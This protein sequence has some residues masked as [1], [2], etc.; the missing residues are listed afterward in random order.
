MKKTRLFVFA[1]LIEAA[2]ASC[3]KEENFEPQQQPE[4]PEVATVPFELSAC[5]ENSQMPTRLSL[6]KDFKPAWEEGDQLG[7]YDGVKIQ[8]FDLTNLE[9]STFTGSLAEGATQLNAIYPYGSATAFSGGKFT[10]SIP[11]EQVIEQGDSLATDA[12]LAMAQPV[13]IGEGQVQF[14]F[15]N[16]CGLI[17]F[18]ISKAGQVKEFIISGNKGEKFA[19]E[20]VIGFETRIEN[21]VEK[22][23]PVFAPSENAATVVKVRPA[24]ENATFAK[25]TYYA[26]VAPVT[27]AE[28]FSVTLLT[29][30]DA[31]TVSKGTD[32]EMIVPRNSGMGLQDLVSIAEWDWKIYTVEQLLAWNAAPTSPNHRVQLME[33]LNM[34]G[35]KWTPKTFQGVFEGNGHKIYNFTIN[36]NGHCG[37]VEYLNKDAVI[38][39]LIL[40]S[41][42]G[43]T[44][45]GVSKFTY[46]PGETAGSWVHVGSVAAKVEGTALVENV[47]NFIHLETPD[48]DGQA[49]VCMGG[50][51]SMGT[52][53][54][55]IKNCVNYGNVTCNANVGVV[56]GASNHQLGGIL[57][58]TDGSTQII[59]CKNYGTITA[60]G[61]YV[62]NI[63]GIIANPNGNGSEYYD[64]A[65]KNEVKDVLPLI[66]DCYNYGNI[67]VT[68]A[69]SDAEATPMALG[70]IVGKLTGATVE[71][72]HNQGNISSV[73]DVLTAMGGVAGRHAYAFESKV[74][75]CSNGV[76]GS[77]DKGILSFSPANG[78]QQAVLGGILGYTDWIK[79]EATGETDDNGDEIKEVVASGKV[80]IQNCNN[81]A[82]INFSYNKMRMVGGVV[83]ACAKISTK[84]AATISCE[85]LIDNCHNYGD[86]TIGGSGSFGGWQRQIGGVV[87]AVNGSMK[88]VEVSNCSNNATLSTTATGGGEH[89]LS[90]IIGYAYA[91]GTLPISV[92]SCNN[93]GEVKATGSATNPRPAGIVSVMDG[94]GVTVNGCYNKGKISTAS[95]V[96]NVYIGGITAYSVR[97]TITDCHNEGDVQVTKT[98]GQIRMGGVA[99]QQTTSGKVLQCTNSATVN[100]TAE[101]TGVESQIGGIVGF[102]ASNALVQSCKNKSTAIISVTGALEKPK[103]GGIVG[104][105]EVTVQDCHNEG[106]VELT[107]TAGLINMGG[108]VGCQKS[109]AKV[110]QCTNAADVYCAA[111]YVASES[112]IGGM[113]GRSESG[114]QVTNCTNKSTA[115]ITVTG[116]SHN[117]R[118]GGITGFAESV[119]I[120]DNVNEGHVTTS[121]V[122]TSKKPTPYVGGI[123]GWAKTL[124]IEN[125]QNKGLVD[126][127]ACSNIP[128]VSGILGKASTNVTIK[129]CRNAQTGKVHCDVSTGTFFTGGIIAQC[130][131]TTKLQYCYNDGEV[132]INQKAQHAYVGGI[133]GRALN[134][135]ENCENT[136]TG[137]VIVQHTGANEKY[138]LAGGIAGRAIYVE[139]TD[140]VI[141]CKSL[142][143]NCKNYGTVKALVNTSNNLTGA[144]GIVGNT[145]TTTV[146]GNVNEGYVYAENA[147]ASSGRVYVGGIIA[148]DMENA[149]K[150]GA[151]SITGNRNYGKVEVKSVK[152]AANTVYK[153]MPGAAA[154]GLFGL[155]ARTENTVIAADNYNYGEV[156]ATDATANGPAGALAGAS[157]IGAWSGNVGKN[158]KVN[159]VLWN[160][161]TNEAAWLCPN[162]ANA[163]TANYV[164]A[165]AA[166]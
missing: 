87:G 33:D 39:N 80:S 32:K 105:S 43:E 154:G 85:V 65:K 134:V 73:C 98:G 52:Y 78:T 47:T 136:S 117:P 116:S 165:P 7:V 90:G 14:A 153:T 130:E 40:G 13:E 10:A 5:T 53:K 37:F 11:A 115:T 106:R 132:K 145:Q 15:K 127:T 126:A 60:G 122:E 144:G 86:I 109:V 148:T 147:H 92:K 18:E 141:T 64:A 159:G 46:T 35:V 163:L 101:I 79:S 42:D 156:V 17:R 104:H 100:S 3:Q 6:G 157:A 146:T 140:K 83:G 91:S 155:I 16:V 84:D 21:E 103:L 22:Q 160:T 121:T 114:T 12:L 164:E 162:A 1:A 94:T 23:V 96:G 89:R 93:F 95:S 112:Q 71:N 31:A 58:K 24:G 166:N 25:G 45:D 124:T 138:A 61:A 77:S 48:S 151:E 29:V 118:I 69:V 81:Y 150:V 120:T 67:V 75:G 158:V 4:A 49:K 128:Y 129:N 152:S 82:P 66:K 57:S 38:R 2:F 142:I 74:D 20:G 59:G 139:N 63:G 51:T 62:D 102:A 97:T 137:V 110:L 34:E 26:A 88:S 70:G 8:Q 41:K 125:C 76:S 113:V 119:T 123:A 68:K 143:K 28:G 131:T 99:G 19:G 56:T 50:I 72:C 27:F 36:R 133:V 44:Y 107:K 108:I 149:S 135:V 9:T 30:N 55:T 111:N 161:W 54:E